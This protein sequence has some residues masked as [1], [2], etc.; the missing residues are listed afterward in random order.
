MPVDFRVAA[1]G[2]A[3]NARQAESG[4]PDRDI[5]YER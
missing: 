5:L 2:L 1:F 4:T 3:R